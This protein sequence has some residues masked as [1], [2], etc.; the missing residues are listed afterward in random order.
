MESTNIP[1]ESTLPEDIKSEELNTNNLS[2]A[3]IFAPIF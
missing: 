3:P 2:F 1:P